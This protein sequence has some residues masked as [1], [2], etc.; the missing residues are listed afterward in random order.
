ME[1]DLDII[2][3]EIDVFLSLQPSSVPLSGP[4]IDAIMA[5]D[6]FNEGIVRTP[7]FGGGTGHFPHQTHAAQHNNPKP[8]P[9]YHNQHQRGGRGSPHANNRVP[10][11]RQNVK[12][13]SYHDKLLREI[14]S[15]LNKVNTSNMD[16]C[17]RR[18]SK[19]VDANNARMIADIIL[20]KCCTNG[21]YMSQLTQL[22]SDIMASHGDVASVAV[23]E[24]VENFI[25]N[26]D[27]VVEDMA[28]IDYENY[29][30]F[31][32]F[33][34]V[35]TQTLSTNKLVLTFLKND[36]VGNLPCADLYFDNLLDIIKTKSMAGHIQDL[37]V[38]MIAC[39][40]EIFNC[41]VSF[42]KFLEMYEHVKGSLIT[43]SKF[44]FQDIIQKQH[45]SCGRQQPR[46]RCKSMRD[47][48]KA[49]R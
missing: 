3:V 40:F 32:K 41:Q 29:D 12:Q 2:V 42:Q 17:V 44:I 35:K 8:Q 39:Y 15:N 31:C 37:L 16:A 26:L 48:Q 20:K 47:A 23:A 27:A 10:A 5:L 1:G 33:T 14:T 28:K 45:D 4:K 9:Q 11:P 38:Q 34:L 21:A 22:L 25:N 49:G 43:K 19:I 46:F 18:I 13:L 36:V 30:E 7:K 24:L 6:C